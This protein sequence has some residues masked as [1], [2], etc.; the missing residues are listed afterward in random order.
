MDGSRCGQRQIERLRLR[1]T[2][3]RKHAVYFSNK[4]ARQTQHGVRGGTAGSEHDVVYRVREGLSIIDRRGNVDYARMRGD[5]RDE[6]KEKHA[7][8]PI[9]VKSLRRVV[10]GGEHDAARLVKRFK[11][12]GE[13]ERICDIRHVKLVE[14]NQNIVHRDLLRDLHDRVLLTRQRQMA[15]SALLRDLR[16]LVLMQLSMELLHELVEVDSAFPSVHFAV[17]EKQI[18]QKAFPRSHVSVEVNPAR[19]S[20]DRALLASALRQRKRFLRF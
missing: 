12:V 15:R 16:L 17:A 5:Q 1:R 7:I 6:G 2:Q 9:H 4:Q 10:A 19:D 8:Q 13:N 11:N 14:T 20:R 18:H 3:L